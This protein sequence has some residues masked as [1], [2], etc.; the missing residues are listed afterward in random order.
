M[1]RIRGKE[2]TLNVVVDGQVLAGSFVKVNDFTA[3][4]RADLVEK[5]YIGESEDDLDVNHKGWDLSFSIDVEDEGPLTLYQDIADRERGNQTHPLIILVATYNYRKPGVS[6]RTVRYQKV[7]LKV[8]EE[9]HSGK[10]EYV[11]V[12]FSGKCKRRSVTAG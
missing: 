3:T 6:K 7:F 9:G 1:S 4:P 8:D 2:V 10:N 12:K 5:P 11:S